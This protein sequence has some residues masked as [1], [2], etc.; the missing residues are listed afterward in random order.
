MTAS[1]IVIRITDLLLGTYSI[2]IFAN[3]I[4]SWIMPPTNALKQFLEFLTA[5]VLRPIRKL[6]QPLMAKSSL[7]LD[8]SPF[9]AM[10]LIILLR[11]LLNILW[12]SI[13]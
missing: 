4:L 2:I 8:F 12:I 10:I 9:V 3:V 7:P 11:Q 13:L 5:P 6:L 1:M